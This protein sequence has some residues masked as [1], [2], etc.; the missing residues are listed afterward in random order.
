[1]G[2]KKKLTLKQMEK[3]QRRKEQREREKKAAATTPGVEK[4]KVADVIPPDVN[5]EKVIQEIR[6]MRAITP[7]QV[8]S[9]FNLRLSVAKDF[10]K[11]LQRHGIIEFV[12]KGPNLEIYRPC[13]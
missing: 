3:I 13:D 8:A 11:S 2:G 7:Y 4:K 9:R 10:L 5:D 6:R 12:S 1:M